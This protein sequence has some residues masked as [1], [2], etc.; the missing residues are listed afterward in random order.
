MT[1]TLT[2]SKQIRVGKGLLGFPFWVMASH[3][4]AV[5]AG[6]QAAGHIPATVKGKERIDFFAHTY[7]AFSFPI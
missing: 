5:T 6:T 2:T 1:D 4:K 7:P 3:F